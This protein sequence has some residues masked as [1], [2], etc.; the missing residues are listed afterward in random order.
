M[1]TRRTLGAGRLGRRIGVV[2]TSVLALAV[3]PAV[4]AA[5]GRDVRLEDR[6]D[7]A[8]FNAAVGP[9]TCVGGGDVTFQELLDRVNPH[10]GGHGAW[11]FSRRDVE[12]KRG[13][14]L[15]LTN[16]G[17][18]VHS[19]TEVFA[20]GTGIVPALNHALP[21]GAPP[22]VPLPGDPRFLPAGGRTTIAGL[23]PGTHRYMCLIH[24]WMRTTVE[25]R[26]R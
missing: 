17:G 26:A 5:D 6:C 1:A 18:E 15:S 16:T 4:A 3:L 21:A 8:T 10:D 14:R 9:G 12:L 23:A 25:Q 19:F 13:E 7:P 11:R 24:P 20:Y 22:A 2:L